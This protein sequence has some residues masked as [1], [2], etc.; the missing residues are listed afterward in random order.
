MAEGLDK[1][2][3][4][5][6][7]RELKKGDEKPE[8]K[9]YGIAEPEESEEEAPP[10]R[11]LDANELAKTERLNAK[12]STAKNINLAGFG[13]NSS[14]IF[15]VLIYGD[16]VLSNP[17]TI[18]QLNMINEMFGLEIDFEGIIKMIQD[19]KMQIVGLC[20]SSQTFIYGYKDLVAKQAEQGN[21]DFMEVLNSELGKV[22]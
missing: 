7:S 6:F 11:N 16:S 22:I 13:I 17:D 18:L 10:V 19:F 4:F 12:L 1:S 20:V 8:K 9:P 3:G 15:S 5:S 21:E 14:A 2:G